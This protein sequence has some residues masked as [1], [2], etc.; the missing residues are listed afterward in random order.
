MSSRFPKSVYGIGDEPDARFS[1]AN[2]RTFLAWITFALASISLGVGLESFALNLRPVCRL[3]ASLLLIALGTFI[4]IQAWFGW[5][6]VERSLRRGEPLPSL[7][8]GMLTVAGVVLAGL[9]VAL[10]VVFR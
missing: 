6:R 3:A 5:Q 7:W 2:E 10:G 1:L 8:H 4:P 9:L